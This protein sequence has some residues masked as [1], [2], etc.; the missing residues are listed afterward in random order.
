M[1]TFLEKLFARPEW[2]FAVVVSFVAFAV[3]IVLSIY[4]QAL[5]IDYLYPNKEIDT[6]RKARVTSGIL[7]GTWVCFASGALSL[8]VFAV[9]NLL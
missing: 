1:V 5:V 8:I 3:S 6:E 9:K 2:K 7:I 4:A